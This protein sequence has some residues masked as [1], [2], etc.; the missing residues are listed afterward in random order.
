MRYTHCSWSV[1]RPPIIIFIIII[2]IIVPTRPESTNGCHHTGCMIDM[3]WYHRRVKR[4]QFGFLRMA[5]SNWRKEVM[6]MYVCVRKFQSKRW[7][8]SSRLTAA[9]IMIQTRNKLNGTF[10]CGS[11]TIR[12]TLL[13]YRRRIVYERTN[14]MDCGW[15]QGHETNR[16][17][18]T[19]GENVETSWLGY[20][21]EFRTACDVT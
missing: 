2:I 13:V 15:G 9:P 16:Y 8:E 20:F 7:N 3:D 14:L 5:Q 11:E 1:F 6:C 21:C 10:R 12:I 19:I 17:A 18:K 4:Y